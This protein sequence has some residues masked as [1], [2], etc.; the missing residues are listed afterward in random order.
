MHILID[1][2]AC[3][4]V[5]IIDRVAQEKGIPV[6]LLIDTNHVFASDTMEV[7]V[8]GAGRDAVDFALVNLTQKGDLV[9]TQD[10][11]VAAMALA[12]GARVLHQ[13]GKE[14]T[15]ENIDGL[16]HDRYLHAKERRTSG[17]HHLKGPAKRTPDDNA[18][19]EAALLKIVN[20]NSSGN[21][22]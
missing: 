6:T 18:R 12:K 1:G 10:Y 2:D 16:L 5:P 9:I 21:N 19:F 8:I 4:V 14:F 7:K 3:P 17:K 20:K 15:D 13:S 11:G 22:P